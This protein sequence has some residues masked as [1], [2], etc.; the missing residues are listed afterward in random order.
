MTTTDDIAAIR[1]V[2]TDWVLHGWYLKT[3]DTFNF[4]AQL[5][6]FYDWDARDVVLHDNADANR[7]IAR[8]AQEYAAI[9][10]TSLDTLRSL[11]NTL[12]DGPHIVVHGDL[13]VV[14]VRFTSR[15]EFVPGQVEVAPTR[16]SLALRRR[17]GQWLIFREHGSNLSPVT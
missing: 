15:F 3:G 13:A 2:V 16:S 10:D 6:R 11:T 9:W 8:S 1:Q 17:R 5:E 4:R 12:D 7:T 14:D